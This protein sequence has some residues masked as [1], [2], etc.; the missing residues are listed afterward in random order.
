M[1]RSSGPSLEALSAHCHPCGVNIRTT[2]LAAASL[3]THIWVDRVPLWLEA[4]FKATLCLDHKDKLLS[5]P[6]RVLIPR[7]PPTAK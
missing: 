6:L 7:L 2:E 1:S 5:A 3:V 4:H